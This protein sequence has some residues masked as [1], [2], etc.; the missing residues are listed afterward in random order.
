MQK[1]TMGSVLT[2][3]NRRKCGKTHFFFVF[4]FFFVNL[5]YWNQPCADCWIRFVYSAVIFCPLGAAIW[6]AGRVS[7]ALKKQASGVLLM[8]GGAHSAHFLPNFRRFGPHGVE[9]GPKNRKNSA[10]TPVLGHFRGSGTDFCA[11][12]GAENGEM[13]FLAPEARKN[14]EDCA[15]N[16]SESDSEM[17]IACEMRRKTGAKTADFGENS[18]N[19][20]G[21]GDENSGNRAFWADSCELGLIYQYFT[22]YLVSG[23][24]AFS[25]LGVPITPATVARASYA[26]VSVG[27]ALVARGLD[28][29]YG[30]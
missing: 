26:F 17:R 3:K 21:F 8:A 22:L 14:G 23:A 6:A 18:R 2:P 30:T 10:K 9:M 12:F 28:R 15:E 29:G 7:S 20:S 13:P 11:E 5:R 19:L 16:S 4:F 25:V 27:A 24:S 1:S